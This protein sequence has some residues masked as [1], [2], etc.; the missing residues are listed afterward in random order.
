MLLK[1]Y[2]EE[3]VKII[4]EMLAT[5]AIGLCGFLILSRGARSAEFDFLDLGL[6]TLVEIII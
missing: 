2:E 6:L 4:R 5:A 1:L 3:M